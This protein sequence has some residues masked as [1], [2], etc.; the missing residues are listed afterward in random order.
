ML[1]AGLVAT[2]SRIKR[3]LDGGPGGGKSEQKGKAGGAMAP[4]AAGS[5]GARAL[6][7]EEPRPQ[8][9]GTRGVGLQSGRAQRPVCTVV[10]SESLLK[11]GW[12]WAS[13]QAG[14]QQGA[15][16]PPTCIIGLSESL[17]EL[18]WAW[19]SLQAREQREGT[20]VD[21]HAQ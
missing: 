16:V 5:R 18:G 19:A 11:P 20:C 15:T 2:T 21:P 3:D 1:L 12:A 6:R 4:G 9:T 10:P 7:A 13:L 17:L 14:G 8:G